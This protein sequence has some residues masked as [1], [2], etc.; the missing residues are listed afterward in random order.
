MAYQM[1]RQTGQKTCCKTYSGVDGMFL[2]CFECRPIQFETTYTVNILVYL[3]ILKSDLSSLP[4]L[5][6]LVLQHK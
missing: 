3:S 4:I 5:K 1:Y 6:N 2:S